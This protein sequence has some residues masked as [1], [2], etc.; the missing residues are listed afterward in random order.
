MGLA[1]LNQTGSRGAGSPGADECSQD[2]DEGTRELLGKSVQSR[3]ATDEHQG[4]CARQEGVFALGG[5]RVR[6][7]GSVHSLL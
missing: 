6:A 3:I 1:L 2:A 5:E 4:R 7:A